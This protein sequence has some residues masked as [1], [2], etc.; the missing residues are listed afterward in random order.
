MRLNLKPALTF[1]T[2]DAY[3]KRKL[4][5]GGLLFFPFPPLGWIMALGFRSLTG[6]RVVEGKEPVLPSWSGNW[7]LI[8]K[9][10]IIAVGVILAH[11]SPFLI[12]Y[13][14]FGVPADAGIADYSW[15]LGLF[16]AAI[17]LFPPLF[18][19]TLPFAY[20]LAFEWLTFS[21]AE[22][23]ALALL[24]IGAIFILPASFV[25]VGLYGDY[26][27]AFRAGAAWR[28]AV[29]NWKLYAEAWFLSLIVSAAA[30]LMG[31]FMA[32]GLF[33]SYLVIL[34]VFLEALVKSGTPEVAERFAKSTVLPPT[35][36]RKH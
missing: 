34:H 19:P 9:R 14:L 17:A 32:W 16:I 4:F 26:A 28:F 18:L 12:C 6:P 33:W 22:I 8:L 36:A 27:A 7:L 11:F 2:R 29:R 15:E 23:A 1:M 31:P 20:A 30:V 13:W 21:V 35:P 3:W 5:I 10:G 25:Q 24:F